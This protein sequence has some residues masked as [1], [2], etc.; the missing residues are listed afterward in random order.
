MDLR[1]VATL[2]LMGPAFLGCDLIQR[3]LIAPLSKLLPG[4]RDVL[5]TGWQHFVAHLV[6]FILRHPGGV[7]ISRLPRIPAAEGVLVLMNHQSLVDIPLVV[8]A[9]HGPYPRILTRSR[10]GRGIPLISHMTR[11]YRFPLVEPRAILRGELEQLRRQG[12]SS[13][14]PLVVFPEGTRTRTGAIGPFKTLGLA[15]LLAARRWTVY[16]VVVDGLWKWA[17]FKDF[18]EKLSLIRVRVECRGPYGSPPPDSDLQPFIVEMRDVMTGML[19]EVR[20]QPVG[21]E[22]G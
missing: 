9:M 19:A 11:L 14:H 2:I 18:L 15:T 1:S 5:L 8:A 17:R 4:R 22:G 16:V 7:R 12:A 10:Y 3:F 6:L 13:S 20:G 21:E